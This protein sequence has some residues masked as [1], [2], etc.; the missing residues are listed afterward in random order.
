MS[1]GQSSMSGCTRGRSFT[2]L[3]APPECAASGRVIQAGCQLWINQTNWK[4]HEALF[5]VASAIYG[6]LSKKQCVVQY[7]KEGGD[8]AGAVVLGQDC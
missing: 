7:L 6:K 2:G 3:F 1:I 4:S 5:K 8:H